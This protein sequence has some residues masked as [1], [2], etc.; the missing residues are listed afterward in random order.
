M[1]CPWGAG[2]QEPPRSQ[3]Q[4]EDKAAAQVLFDEG[5]TLMDAERYGEACPKFAESLRLDAALG[6]QLNLARCYQLVGKTASAWIL[7]LEAAALANDGPCSLGLCF[8]VSR[9]SPPR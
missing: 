8:P 1:A 5:R 7:Y 3:Q 4:A 9:Q 6:T 2:A